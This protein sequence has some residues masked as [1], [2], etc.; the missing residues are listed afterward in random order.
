[1]NI[2]L[3][4]LTLF[5]NFNQKWVIPQGTVGNAGRILVCDSDRD[6][7]F[8][9]IF[10]TY[11]EFAI[12]FYEL[13]PPT[14]WV[15]DTIPY[16]NAPILWDFGDFDSD[17]LYDLVMQCGCVDPYW[18]GITIFES[19]DSFSYPTW[20]VW[21]DTV[22]QAV[23]Q[24]ISAFDID[25]DGI[26]EFVTNDGNPPNWLWIY[27]S[28]GNNQYDTVFTG[29]PD[30]SGL[31]GPVSTHA[32]GDFDRNEKIE[33]VVGGMSA[34]ALGAT[35]W[36]YECSAN[37]AYDQILHGY[38]ATKNIKDCFSVPDA[39]SD[40]KLEFVVKGFF[41][42]GAEINAFIFEATGDNTYEIV[43]S[44]T[45]PGG[46][47]YGG[48][49]D[50][51][52]VD[53]DSIPEIVLEARQYIYIIKAAGNDSFFVWDTLPGNVSGSTIR[54]TDDIDGDGLN[55]I[56]I[57]GNNQTRIYEYEQGAIEETAL[58]K[59]SNALLLGIYPNPFTQ[60]LNIKLRSPT[61]GKYSIKTYDISGKLVINI[62][63][64]LINKNAIIN[65]N[66]NDEKGR[67]VPQGVYFLK[68]DNLE[69]KA[70]EVFKVLRTR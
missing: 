13:H 62:Y 35:Y 14:T 58:N 16:A 33:L 54:V 2:L 56:V 15:V 20:E 57:S 26:A 46:D 52:D 70:T 10:T 44:M 45:F 50:A 30:T 8:E 31:D 12:Y 59:N 28:S 48:Y 38:V 41:I 17:G 39:D 37:N 40:G 42:P 5:A 19:P 25:L 47:Y 22:G 21:R 64:G 4:A 53:G 66:G 68:V 27:K 7:Y 11:G 1:M 49:S 9:L 34:G 23:V 51:G 29:N 24:P 18:V 43:K 60:T 69:T 63:N 67:P 32:F 61:N 65:W 6:G 3:I 55:E 36:I